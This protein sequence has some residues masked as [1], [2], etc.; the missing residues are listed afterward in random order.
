MSPI[1][2]F[3][4]DK[5]KRFATRRNRK[6]PAGW[7]QARKSDSALYSQMRGVG[8]LRGFVSSL[9]FASPEDE[10]RSRYFHA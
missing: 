7:V 9:R 6:M 4:L 10:Q 2:L 5:R 8:Q 3:R 1:D